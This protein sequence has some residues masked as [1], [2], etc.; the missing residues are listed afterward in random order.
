MVVVAKRLSTIPKYSISLYSAQATHPD[1]AKKIKANIVLIV[2][3]WLNV[4]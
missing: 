2:F 1:A 3:I 4:Y